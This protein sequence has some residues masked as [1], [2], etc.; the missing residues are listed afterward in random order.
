MRDPV[1]AHFYPEPRC[2][3]G[4]FLGEKNLA[5]SLI[6]LSDGLSTDLTRLCEASNVG[7]RIWA[8]QIPVPDIPFGSKAGS[9]RAMDLALN[10]GEDYEL[11]FSVP[12]RKTK[13]IAGRF[14]NVPL[15]CIGEI[16]RSKE[17]LLV[18]PDGKQSRLNP[19]GYDHFV[20]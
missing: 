18:M 15:H 20:K 7:A 19:A 6:D 8:E 2:A 10:G 14:N 11:L 1:R 13:Q 9:L 12:R 5:S 17:V 16:C 3:L 4:R